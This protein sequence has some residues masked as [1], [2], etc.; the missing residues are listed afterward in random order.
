MNNGF[1]IGGGANCGEGIYSYYNLPKIS[2]DEH[3]I[4]SEVL[5]LDKFFI[6]DLDIAKIVYGDKYSYIDQLTYIMGE[7]WIKKI[8]LSNLND[9]LDYASFLPFL[10]QGRYKR[11]DSIAVKTQKT[12]AGK[13]LKGWIRNHHDYQ[14]STDMVWVICYDEK[15]IKPIKLIK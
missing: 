2:K 3:V 13:E 1:K 14:L 6:Q 12:V 9:N 5:S 7:D 8:N 15:N 11:T 10:N 4:E